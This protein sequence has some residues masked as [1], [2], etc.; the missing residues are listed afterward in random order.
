[1]THPE[2]QEWM[3]PYFWE[4]LELIIRTCIQLVMADVYKRQRYACRRGDSQ[5]NDL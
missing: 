5:R 2:L 4:E 3:S 1:M